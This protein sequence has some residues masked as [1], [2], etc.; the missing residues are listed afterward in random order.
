MPGSIFV[1]SNPSLRNRRSGP[2]SGLSG[3]FPV[4]NTY[5]FMCRS[6]REFEAI[7][8]I[9]IKM[10]QLIEPELEEALAKESAERAA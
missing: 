9:Y 5:H 10:F 7:L 8:R 1:P 6:R 3:I 4:P 2:Y